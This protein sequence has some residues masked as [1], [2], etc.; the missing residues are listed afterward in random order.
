[1][2]GLMEPKYRVGMENRAESSV[3]APGGQARAG[4]VVGIGEEEVGRAQLRE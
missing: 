1:M 2:V 3:K 4:A